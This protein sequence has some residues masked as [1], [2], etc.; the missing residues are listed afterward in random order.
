MAGNALHNI[1]DFLHPHVRHAITTSVD[2]AADEDELEAAPLPK[3]PK[4]HLRRQA[5]KISQGKPVDRI[6]TLLPEALGDQQADGS[7][8]AGTF[9][10]VDGHELNENAAVVTVLAY[11]L[12]DASEA[13]PR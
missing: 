7:P 3:D 13:A 5:L 6:T 9:D 10:K 11:A 1:F 2:V 8:P 4:I 12:A